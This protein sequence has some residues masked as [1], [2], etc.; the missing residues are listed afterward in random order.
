[1]MKRFFLA[2][3]LIFTIFP[4]FAQNEDY[5]DE[6]PE[7]SLLTK[8]FGGKKYTIEPYV[9]QRCP[10]AVRAAIDTIPTDDKY[11]DIVLFDD[12][13]WDY[14]YHSR[15]GIDST[16]VFDGY[17]STE[18]LYVYKKYPVSEIPSEVDLVL[19][20][21]NHGYCPPV[22]SKVTSK[23]RVRHSRPHTGVDLDLD[24]GDTVRVAFDGIVR[25]SSGSKETGGYGN[26]IIVRHS[27]GL[28]T[29]YAH[30]SK[31]LVVPGEPVRAGDPIGLGGSTGHST[32]PHLHFEMRYKGQTFDPERVFNFETGRIIANREF[33][34]RKDYFS[35]Y[36]H[37]GQTDAESLAASQAVYYKVKSGDTL[38]KIAARNGTTVAKICKLNGISSTKVLRIGE[39]L[40]IR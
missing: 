38:G 26:L 24:T 40:R 33:T 14:L 8:V 36:S 12:Q 21:E 28:E 10:G 30:L 16:Y 27:N 31:R 15:P 13:T 20:D 2:S 25:C 11:V 5:F 23:Y 34:L 29:Y 19:F 18:D 35:I 32:G 7:P 17:W 22:I 6:T 39:R 1:M 4:L 37:N 3:I 9:I